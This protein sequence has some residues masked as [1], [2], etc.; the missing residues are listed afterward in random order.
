R[1]LAH[2]YLRIAGK[3]DFYHEKHLSYWGLRNLCRDFH[4]IDYSHKVIAEPERFGV[5]YMLKPGSTKHRLARLVATTLPWL[6]PH[7]W[8]LQKPASIADAG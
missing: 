7:I 1:P 3:G 5:E 2:R 6:A 8:L 4:I